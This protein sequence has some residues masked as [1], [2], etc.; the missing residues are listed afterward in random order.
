MVKTLPIYTVMPEIKETLKNH[1]RLVIQAPPGA[2]KTTVIPLELL[3]ESWMDSRKIIMLEPR[4]I[5][6]RSAAYWMAKTLGETVGKRVGYSVHLDRKVSSETV[7][8]VVTEGVFINR[9]LQDPELSDISLVIFDEFHERSLEADLAL[10]LIRESQDVLR[11]DLKIIVM[12]ATVDAEPVA[13]YLQDCPI[14]SS[15]GKCYPVD[16]KY[17][18]SHDGDLISHVVSTVLHA[19]NSEYGSILLFLPGVG[20]IKRV[21]SKLEEKLSPEILIQPLYGALPVVEQEK[22]IEPVEKGFRKVVLATSIA[23]SS[24]TIKGIRIVIDSGLIRKPRFNPKTGMDSLET[25]IIS[26]ASADQ[27]TGRA[28]RVESG[29]CYRLW[30]SHRKLDDFSEPAIITEDLCTV[31]LT[32]AKWGYS[33]S[34]NVHWLT[35]PNS[36]IFISSRDLLLSL[37][38]IDSVGI[39]EKGKRISRLPLHPRLGAMVLKGELLG[40]KSLAGDIAALLSEKDILGFSGDTYQSDLLYR[41][42]ALKGKHIFNGLINKHT[43]KRVRDY[44]RSLCGKRDNISTEQAGSLLISAYPDRIAKNMGDGKFQLANGSNALLSQGDSLSHCK[45]LIIPSLG[46]TGRVAKIFL[47]AALTEEEILNNLEESLYWT[48]ILDFDKDKGKFTGKK[49]LKLGHLVL[50]EERIGKISDD[51]YQH[52][53]FE[54]L[55]IK[56]LGDLNWSKDTIN[57]RNRVNFLHRQKMEGYPDLNDEFLTEDLNWLASYMGGI[58]LKSPLKEIPLLDALKGIL[59]WNTLKMIDSLAPTHITVPSGSRIPVDYSENEPLLKVRIQQL[60]GMNE[61][62]SICG[63]KYPLIIHLLSPASRPIQITRDLKSFWNNTYRE[64]KK[65]LMGRYPRHY[66]PDDP[67][68]AEATNRVKRK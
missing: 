8:E 6:A 50:K 58:S 63:G 46:G 35:R 31:A 28:G 57:F 34:E 7:I 22:A 51:R 36:E 53:L 10:A 21:Q 4:R 30:E 17:C 48:E 43:I 14:I 19:L 26:K 49:L 2:G 61:S 67:Y 56:G 9:L 1:S 54:Y 3:E 24:I 12:S 29:T 65:D 37:G 32:L 40:I 62:P 41:L 11:E 44:S 60:F 47:S 45:Y 42:E 55:K 16:I 59:D 27:R 39:T 15:A 23:E 64:V 52:S 66:W 18:G 68:E 25:M 13:S 38:A 20:E 33:K 5:A